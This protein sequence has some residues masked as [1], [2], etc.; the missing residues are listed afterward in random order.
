M[1]C[2][3]YVFGLKPDYVHSEKNDF[4]LWISGLENFLESV[5]GTSAITI[6]YSVRCDAAPWV[7]Q[8]FILIG[9]A[10]EV[11]AYLALLPDSARDILADCAYFWI[12]S[13]SAHAGL[14][15][16][17]S[18]SDRVLTL[19]PSSKDYNVVW[20]QLE[21]L[22][23]YPS[24]VGLSRELSAVRSEITRI[25]QETMGPGTPVLVL[26][27]SG[28]GKAFV[29]RALHKANER[30]RWSLRR[31]IVDAI[32]AERGPDLNEI[33]NKSPYCEIACGYFTE[34]L[35]Q[36]QLF[37]HYQGAFADAREDKV[38]LLVKS[39]QGTLTLN[40]FDAAPL[41][42]QAAL[43]GVLDTPR[44][45]CAEIFRLGG[46]NREPEKTWVWLVFTTNADIG[47]LVRQNKLR[48]DF[49]FRFEDR[50]ILLPPLRERLADL[51]SIAKRIWI[52]CWPV[53]PGKEEDSRRRALSPPVLQWIAEQKKTQWQGNIRALRTLLS[54]AASRAKLEQNKARPLQFLLAEIMARGPEYPD[55]LDII[56]GPSC[57][58]LFP[59]EVVSPAPPGPPLDAAIS[60][61]LDTQDP[62]I[63]AVR[64]LSVRELARE[65]RAKLSKG[66][67]RPRFRLAHHN[68]PRPRR[69][70]LIPMSLR[71]A[72][73]LWYVAKVGRIDKHVCVTMNKV[74]ETTAIED[75]DSLVGNQ[76]IKKSERATKGLTS[77][78]PVP[79][80][81]VP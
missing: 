36:D 74:G 65:V 47:S 7:G 31:D 3:L 23:R 14:A 48:E 26:G 70:T 73:I 43:L 75:L 38:G 58:P 54:L 12:L 20:D 69:R 80:V 42:V 33:S 27:E 17:N 50:I 64:Q 22:I 39:S 29:A 56:K 30:T 16:L 15:L 72:H 4:A 13:D 41:G 53:V 51:P 37:G 45:A 62:C 25:A 63:K 6:H 35:L 18:P 78:V 24:L 59:P 81:F 49:L 61:S 55:W 21:D 10:S 67:G 68:A 2:D 46:E 5:A 8:P 40:D 76:L 1:C 71:L 77:Y 28:A 66:I 19:V 52:D 44:S 60:V 11:D 9:T 57:V 32:S 79:G 34:H